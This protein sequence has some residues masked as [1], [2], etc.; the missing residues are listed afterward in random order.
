M[1]EH[2]PMEQLKLLSFFKVSIH[3]IY[4]NILYGGEFLNGE[5]RPDKHPLIHIHMNFFIHKKMEYKILTSNSSNM[6]ENKIIIN[7]EVDEGLCLHTG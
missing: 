6:E 3:A 4:K 5:G 1:D 7:L 2:F